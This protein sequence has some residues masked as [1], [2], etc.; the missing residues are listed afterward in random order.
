M[1]EKKSRRGRG[2]PTGF[3]LRDDLAPDEPSGNGEEREEDGSVFPPAEVVDR[4]PEQEEQ[5]D[6]FREPAS[7]APSAALLLPSPA[8]VI[9][10]KSKED[11]AYESGDLVLWRQ[12][13]AEKRLRRTGIVKRAVAESVV[14]EG[15]DRK[16]TRMVMVQP[17][18][19]KFIKRAEEREGE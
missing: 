10:S 4:V 9:R 1:A 15:T 13:I 18:P 19:K 14:P 7:T 12:L 16:R 6:S 5:A 17:T 11:E 2:A 3:L 8:V